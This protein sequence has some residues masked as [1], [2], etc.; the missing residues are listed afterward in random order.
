MKLTASFLLFFTLNVSA[1]GYGQD[2]ISLRL[3][4]T[5]I[6]DVL[7]TI[8][9]QTN[10]RFLYNNDLTDIREKISINVKDAEL[11][12]VLAV[13]LKRTRL[14]YQVMN[15]NLIVIK[16]DMNIPPDVQIQGR[17]VSDAGAP[18]TGASVLVKG[19]TIGTTT[20]ADGQ[21]SLNA[22]DANV[23]LVISSI[24]FDSQEIAL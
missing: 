19:T 11:S 8:E 7:R 13:V 4:R 17:V 16:E 12:D 21:F 9:K 5:E 1:H 22:P 2:K 24:G 3:K 6:S 20:N 10:Y 23:T 14:L 15:D 18:L